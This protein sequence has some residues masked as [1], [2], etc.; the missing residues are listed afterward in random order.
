MNVR[1]LLSYGF[2]FL[3]IFFLL[4]LKTKISNLVLKTWNNNNNHTDYCCF[5]ILTGL[6][7]HCSLSIVNCS[8]QWTGTLWSISC[9]SKHPFCFYQEDTTFEDVNGNSGIYNS[10]ISKNSWVCQM[11]SD[12][13]VEDFLIDLI[14]MRMDISENSAPSVNNALILK[15]I[16]KSKCHWQLMEL[17]S[18]THSWL[19]KMWHRCLR[20]VNFFFTH[21]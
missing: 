21:R 14:I 7:L 11:N 3:C 16:K 12:G 19:L 20:Y 18:K 17:G 6:S 10:P 13:I 15:G 2:Y 1:F 9:T 5:V 4:H 8:I